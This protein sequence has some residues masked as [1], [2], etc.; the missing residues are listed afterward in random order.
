MARKS[1]RARKRN[2]RISYAEKLARLLTVKQ[3]SYRARKRFT[4]QQKSAITRQW[5]K[6]SRTATRRYKAGE[7]LPPLKVT[8]RVPVKKIE[9]LGRPPRK[10]IPKKP[11]RISRRKVQDTTFY[12]VQ[13]QPFAKI[14]SQ[15]K[16][17]QARK[18]GVRFLIPVK[19][20]PDYPKGVMS[21]AWYNLTEFTDEG[22]EGLL[23]KWGEVGYLAGVQIRG[24]A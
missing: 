19:K 14:F 10:R 5:N 24:Y 20:S 8:R 22:L 12:N 11:P 13:K 7:R 1:T 18:E 6:Y 21:S 3:P 23:E 17:M 9:K 2:P 16:R 4:P 15:L